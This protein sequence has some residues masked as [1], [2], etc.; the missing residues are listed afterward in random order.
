[1]SYKEK[2][3]DKIQTDIGYVRLIYS[4]YKNKDS[5]LVKGYTVQIN[6]PGSGIDSE[7]GFYPNTIEG[8]KTA[9]AR[10]KR[11]CLKELKSTS[12]DPKKFW[13]EHHKTPTRK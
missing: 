11:E 4:E 2:V 6:I 3:L 8:L 12:Y 5:P 7:T 9:K 1:M 13:A 10:F